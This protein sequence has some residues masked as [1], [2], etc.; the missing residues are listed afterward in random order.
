L[1]RLVALAP[2]RG[3][4]ASLRAAMVDFSFLRWAALPISDRRWTAPLSAIALGF[5]LFIGVGMSPGLNA[6]HGTSPIVQLAQSP[7]GV[8]GSHPGD[9]GDSDSPPAL[10]S[11]VANAAAP[12]ASPS[13]GPSVPPPAAPTTTAPPPPTTTTPP[14]TTTTT[15]QTPADTPPDNTDD[16]QIVLKGTV[17][18]VNPEADSYGLTT[19][20]GQ[21][22]AVHARKLPEVGAKLEVPVRELANGTYA[23]DG[24]ETADGHATS[25]KFQGL[26]TYVDPVTGNYTVSRRGSSI[27]VRLDPAAASDPPAVGSLVTVDAAIA[28]V[29]TTVG[30]P[31]DPTP[32]DPAPT[33]PAPT[34]PAPT[35]P[36]PTDPTTTTPTTTT[37]TTSPR[38]VARRATPVIDLAPIVLPDL[39]QGCGTRPRDPDPPENTL[40][41]RS[42]DSGSEFLGYSDFEGTVQGVCPDLGVLILSA[43]DV[44]EAGADLAFA[45]PDDA[46]IDLDSIKPGDVID[47]SATIA[48]DSLDLSLTGISGEGGIGEADDADLAQ[49]DQAG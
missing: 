1:N 48:D 4:V 28:K 21:L 26:V 45:V 9:A 34:E 46:G 24:K 37:P 18:H 5:G 2:T 16:E 19:E 31:T 8:D 17:I 36:A 38:P 23:E 43:D 6:S 27:F 7:E 44:G 10:G 33:E 32:T 30:A 13:A 42:R 20:K 35:D 47:A 40:V 15:D 11:P 39:P 14:P 12:P 29:D 25:A 3:Q 22:S 41:E 49:G